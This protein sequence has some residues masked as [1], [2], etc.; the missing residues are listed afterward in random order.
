[1][2]LCELGLILCVHMRTLSD[3]QIATRS[4]CKHLTFKEIEE[5]GIF[6]YALVGAEDGKS[7]YVLRP[8]RL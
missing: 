4:D 3:T 6:L 7:N 1:M 5:S 8:G 2:N